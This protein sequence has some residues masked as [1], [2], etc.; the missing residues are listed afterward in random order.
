M[1]AALSRAQVLPLAALVGLVLL[2]LIARALRWGVYFRPDRHVRFAPL[3][4]TLS[5]SYMAS[6][7]LPFRA[8]ELVRS[9]F[10]AQREGLP[11]PRIVG[12][13]LLEKLF[14]F[15]AIGVLLVALLVTT[16]LP[17]WAVYTG[18]SLAVVIIGGF[19]FVVA[20]AVLRGPTL[21]LVRWGEGIIPFKVGRRLQLARV[22]EHFA[23]GTDSLRHHALWGPMLFWT[24]VTWVLGTTSYWLGGMA[25]GVNMSLATLAFLAVVTSMGQAVPSSPGYVGVYHAAAVLSLTTFGIEQS[26]AA[27]IAVI[28]HAFSYGALVVYGIVAMWLGHY[29]VGELLAATRSALGLGTRPQAAESSG[30]AS[31]SVAR[32]AHS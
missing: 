13:I 17:D 24:G 4:G 2:S 12:T 30:G 19:G 31:P 3:M 28:I 1:G 11:V 7:L 14:D 22:V 16:P 18:A 29:S 20:L 15:L 27:A 9:M 26:V 5:I 6:T 23:E 32:T 10:L 21:R 25:I 8:G